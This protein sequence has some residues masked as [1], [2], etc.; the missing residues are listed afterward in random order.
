MYPYV[1]EILINIHTMW[2]HCG[3]F[4]VSIYLL[5]T[6]EVKSIKENYVNASFIFIGLVFIADILNKE[7]ED[8]F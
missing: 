5:M 3:S 4:I 2:L 8:T 1:D 7:H 6:G